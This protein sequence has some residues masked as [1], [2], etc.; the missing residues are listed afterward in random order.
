MDVNHDA[1]RKLIRTGGCH[2]ILHGHTHRP[3]IHELPAAGPKPDEP[4]LRVVLG[5]WNRQ[6]W[7]AAIDG[8]RV[9]LHNFP[10]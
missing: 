7:Y 8:A 6:G 5:D 10:L 9:S 3:A 2:R 1:V 4:A